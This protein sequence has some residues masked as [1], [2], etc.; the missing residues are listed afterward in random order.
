MRAIVIST[1]VDNNEQIIKL[2]LLRIPDDKS[3]DAKS[4]FEIIDVTP[5]QLKYVM[6]NNSITVDNVK[7]KGNK[8]VGH[9][10]Q[11][12]RYTKIN[13]DTGNIIGKTPLVILK[14]IKKDGDTI[15][16]VVSDY[17]G[18]V[19]NGAL[20]DI[21]LYS[22]LNGI[23]NGKL[24][25][26]EEKEFISPIIGSYDVLSIKT[27]KK[28]EDKQK[29]V[30]WTIDEFK[31]YMDTH[32]YRYSLINDTLNYVDDRLKTVV[33][34]KGVSNINQFKE[35]IDT[36]DAKYSMIETIIL[37]DT[38]WYF[39]MNAFSHLPFLKRII[40]DPNSRTLNCD[41]FQQVNNGTVEFN[42]PTNI[43]VLRSHNMDLDEAVG[44]LDCNY[45]N[46]KNLKKIYNCCTNIAVKGKLDLGN[47][48]ETI[49]KSISGL[50]GY[51]D[52]I[53]IPSTVTM[54][55]YSF[56]DLDVDNIDF[57]EAVN[58]ERLQY[59]C[60]GS[61]NN[62]KRLDL[63]ACK[64]LKVIDSQCF[65]CCKELEEVIL[66]DSV[67]FIGKQCFS[68]CIKLK[69]IKLPKNLKEL[70]ED[71]FEATA[72]T[73]LVVSNHLSQFS[74]WNK[75]ITV[76]VEETTE[77]PI[78]MFNGVVCKEVILPDSI[79]ELKYQIFRGAYLTF[80][81]PKS[82]KVI[83]SEALYSFQSK[84]K[85]IL[86]FSDCT[87][88]ETIKNR[89]FESSNISGIILPDSVKTIGERAFRSMEN[90][91]WIY[92]PK[93]IESIGKL[94]LQLSGLDVP[95]GTT[96]LTYKD[97]VAD[98][99]CKKNKMKII[100]VESLDE[101][102]DT[103]FVDK[104]EM[105][106]K[107]LRKLRMLLSGD[108]LHSELFRDKYIN[109]AHELWTL[110]SRCK[111]EIEPMELKLNTDKFV[112]VPLNT[113]LSNSDYSRLTASGLSC[114]NTNIFNAYVNYIT[115]FTT[116]H[117]SL[118]DKKYFDIMYSDKIIKEDSLTVM[119]RSGNNRIAKYVLEVESKRLFMYLISIENN[120][121]YCAVY[122][123][124]S[125]NTIKEPDYPIYT[126]STA[127]VESILSNDKEYPFTNA[128]L[129]VDIPNY[130]KRELCNR[131]DTQLMLIGMENTNKF[132]VS[133]RGIE[134]NRVYLYSNCSGNIIKADARCN[135]SSKDERLDKGKIL[136]IAIKEVFN[137]NN[138]PEA[139]YKNIRDSYF[140]QVNVAL[141]LQHLA[142]ND[143][144]LS[145]LKQR[146]NAYDEP[147]ACLEW[148]F[149][150]AIQDAGIKD[151]ESLPHDV[152]EMLLDT[153]FYYKTRK[154][155]TE[156]ASMRKTNQIDIGNGYYT[157]HEYNY[158]PQKKSINYKIIGMQPQYLV[159]LT[160]R[161]KK[162]SGT[163]QC[164]VSNM[165]IRKIFDA[166]Y[167]MRDDGYKAEYYLDNEKTNIHAYYLI[168]PII[169]RYSLY[170]NGS[171]YSLKAGLGI[172]RASGVVFLLASYTNKKGEVSTYKVF[173]Y[174]TLEEA[175]EKSVWIHTDEIIVNNRNFA[176]ITSQL[177]NLLEYI[178]SDKKDVEFNQLI[179]VRNLILDGYPNG[180]ALADSAGYLFDAAAKQRKLS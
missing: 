114:T 94:S 49:N 126:T 43:E 15:G 99:Y 104:P 10:A 47:S 80:N 98:I 116:N 71:C 65:T 12:T 69:Q 160:D 77:I 76:R 159:V 92:L 7:I 100:Y 125:N 96:V 64:K 34:P 48:I 59:N 3:Y 138:I 127:P 54:I 148:E 145:K 155:I 139:D 179:K 163:V 81:I 35:T 18:K 101:A 167:H 33:V 103:I 95:L 31:K 134:L 102:L 57:S 45:S 14:Q 91:R 121:A 13:I 105:N 74:L 84:D 124:S 30:S 22:K 11:L 53:K 27:D 106:E 42:I 67:E 130:I 177:S 153:N 131:F 112:N 178:E 83:S 60:F 161:N 150:K 168:R 2:R 26:R 151:I 142:L 40:I 44:P 86:D 82:L 140:S 144:Y 51:T 25:T 61:L 171:N 149:S 85:G 75:D 146:P 20:N 143:D 137:I 70:R 166:I 32:G 118:L 21:I 128:G 8:L 28:K 147:E 172:N 38:V 174:R 39:N 165:S 90:L 180:Y 109:N 6:G 169:N 46:Y 17:K 135:Y 107:R 52:T 55:D 87:Q 5:Y 108:P 79:E 133:K 157:L 156:L 141:L 4:N 58:L 152:I 162:Y 115:T 1:L 158:S 89:A 9:G 170:Y 41:E 72:I 113:V 110:Y 68:G 119:M 66:P 132:K 122:Y 129:S 29:F 36:S 63:S 62:V 120:A 111:T 136:N 73:E 88:L 24:I 19:V 176:S 78:Q 50:I 93:S 56:F 23:A 173:R 154:K 164:F 175:L 16:Y 117:S 97:C 123:A 37:P